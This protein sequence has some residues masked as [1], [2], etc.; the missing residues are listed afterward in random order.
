MSPTHR[1]SG[2]LFAAAKGAFDDAVRASERL[3]LDLGW[4]EAAALA[5][6]GCFRGRCAALEA[7]AGLGLVR[8]RRVTEGWKHFAIFA[9]S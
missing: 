2:R 7:A 1:S 9:R 6:S 8:P 3:G 5:P 4:V